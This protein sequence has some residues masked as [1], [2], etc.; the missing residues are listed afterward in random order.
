MD[1]GFVALIVFI[2]CAIILAKIIKF[3][4]KIVTLVI[5]A[6]AAAVTIWVCSAQPEIHKPFSVNTIEYLFKINKD[7]SMTTTKQV[8]KT[9]IKKGDTNDE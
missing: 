6:I 1:I 4:L 3:G 8:T 2:I 5:I 9:V 7:G